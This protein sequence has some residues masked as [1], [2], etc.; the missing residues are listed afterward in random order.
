MRRLVQRGAYP[1]LLEEA[2]QGR[3]TAP[4]LSAGGFDTGHYSWEG[5]WGGGRDSVRVHACRQAGCKA[6]HVHHP[7]L[8]AAPHP[9]PRHPLLFVALAARRCGARSKRRVACS[10]TVRRCKTSMSGHAWAAT[11]ASHG[12]RSPRQ[13][14]SL[15]AM[16]AMARSHTSASLA[17]PQGAVATDSFPRAAGKPRLGS[18][19]GGRVQGARACAGEA[20]GG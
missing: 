3:G 18:R 8:S 6:V 2:A 11:T 14:A 19:P 13:R 5:L 4:L 20:G 17:M 7:L 15:A 12:P 9:L 1:A 10:L 16:V